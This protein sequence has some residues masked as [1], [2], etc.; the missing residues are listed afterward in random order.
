LIPLDESPTWL[1]LMTREITHMKAFAAALESMKKPAF[2]VGKIAPTP[3]ASLSVGRRPFW[4]LRPPACLFEG[5]FF[6]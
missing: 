5:P 4:L 3:G 6:R 1:L 2:S